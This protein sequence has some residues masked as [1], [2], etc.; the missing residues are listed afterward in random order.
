M[1]GLP[2]ELPLVFPNLGR[3]VFLEENSRW[4]VL[5]VELDVATGE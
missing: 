4:F 1:C 2:A 5:V 3:M